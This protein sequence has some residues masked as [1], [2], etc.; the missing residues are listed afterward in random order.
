MEDARGELPLPMC[1]I[2]T[3]I[4]DG[5]LP[6]HRPVARTASRHQQRRSLVGSLRVSRVFG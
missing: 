6:T 1:H 3:D 4:S 5:Q 2:A